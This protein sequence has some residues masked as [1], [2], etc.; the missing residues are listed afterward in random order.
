MQTIL[1]HQAITQT[2]TH[3]QTVLCHQAITQTY[4]HMLNNAHGPSIVL[5][6]SVDSL[7]LW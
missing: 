2:Y 4:T 7:T 6:I 5:F 3:M 1:C